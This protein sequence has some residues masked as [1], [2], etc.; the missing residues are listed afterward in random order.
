MDTNT[1]LIS[2]DSYDLLKYIASHP[3]FSLQEHSSFSEDCLNQLIRYNFVTCV[4]TA[5]DDSLFPVEE[6][7][8]ITELGKGFL[9]GKQSDE[10]FQQ[11]AKDIAD[12]ALKTANK[13]DIK[14]WISI[15]ISFVAL[16]WS[17]ISPFILQILQTK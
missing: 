4:A 11:S 8:S 15:A 9:W 10:Q 6:S 1:V 7:F 13:A 5:Y 17:I 12:A 2:T 3:N 14:G 16:I